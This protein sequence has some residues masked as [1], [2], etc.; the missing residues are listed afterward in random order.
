MTGHTD[1]TGRDTVAQESFVAAELEGRGTDTSSEY[2]LVQRGEQQLDP[3]DDGRPRRVRGHDP[4]A[5]ADPDHVDSEIG[6]FAVVTGLNISAQKF[7]LWKGTPGSGILL[8]SAL[9]TEKR[10]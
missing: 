10:P 2:K 5:S 3:A 6:T 7:E 9:K 8:W 4:R 1:G